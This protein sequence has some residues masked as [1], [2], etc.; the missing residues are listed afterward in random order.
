[1]S[2]AAEGGTGIGSEEDWVDTYEPEFD[3]FRAA[4]GWALRNEPAIAARIAGRLT[5]CWSHFGLD[6]EGLRHSEA[7][8][9]ALPDP[10][11]LDAFAV[12]VSIAIH[13]RTLG[14]TR[15]A[16]DAGERALAIALAND[17]PQRA[18]EARSVAGW[19]RFVLGDHGPRACRVEGSRRVRAH[20][21]IVRRAWR[22]R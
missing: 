3:N 6:A 8:L 4:I 16:L 18:S 21:R 7:A 14:A 22:A 17:D 5:P 11:S 12:W 13:A 15:R 20:A 1:M 2:V 19:P 10:A 9:A